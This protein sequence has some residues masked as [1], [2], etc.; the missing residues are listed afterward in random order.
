MGKPIATSILA[1]CAQRRCA[2]RSP[3]GRSRPGF[4]NLTHELELRQTIEPQRTPRTQRSA[5]PDNLREQPG[6]TE[7]ADPPLRWMSDLGVLC[8]LCGSFLPFFCSDLPAKRLIR[9]R[10]GQLIHRFA[11]VCP[12]CPLCPRWFIRAF[13][14]QRLASA[15]AVADGAGAMVISPP[16]GEHARRVRCTATHP[17][18][19]E[20]IG[21]A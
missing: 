9:I 17:Y 14:S 13:H 2:G 16:Q 4:A 10:V 8:A 20:R 3:L 11:G 6:G 21:I 19:A 18:K 1:G 15:R 12:R 7:A 5:R